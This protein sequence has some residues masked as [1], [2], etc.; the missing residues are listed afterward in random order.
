M[1]PLTDRPGGRQQGRPVVH[2]PY[3]IRSLHGRSLAPAGAECRGSWRVGIRDRGGCLS[4]T[5][6][7]HGST[8]RAVSCTDAGRRK[9]QVGYTEFRAH[10]AT[11]LDRVEEDRAELVVTRQNR[12]DIVVR[13]RAELNSIHETSHLLSTPANAKRLRD[14]VAQL[15]A[16][17]GTAHDLIEP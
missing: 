3:R 15:D 1:R 6:G 7:G 17:A 13:P 16:E 4:Q 10:L 5:V 8:I 14:S 9:S 2:C 12:P 11:Y